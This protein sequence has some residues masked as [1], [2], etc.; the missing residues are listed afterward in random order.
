MWRIGNRARSKNLK[1]EDNVIIVRSRDEWKKE[2]ARLGFLK[3]L[4]QIGVVGKE[5][6]LAQP[7]EVLNQWTLAFFVDGSGQRQ[8][9]ELS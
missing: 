6:C 2:L 5:K 8:L 1:M 4:G 7:H 9:I 3:E